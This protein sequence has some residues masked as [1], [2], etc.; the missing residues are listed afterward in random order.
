MSTIREVMVVAPAVQQSPLKFWFSDVDGA[1]AWAEE[2]RRE[3]VEELGAIARTSASG[4]SRSGSAC[5]SRARRSERQRAPHATIPRSRI[6]T[7]AFAGA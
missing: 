2:G 3:T 5:R 6:S 4:T 1:I 7:R